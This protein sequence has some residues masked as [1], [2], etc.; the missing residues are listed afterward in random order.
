MLYGGLFH[1]FRGLI[2]TGWQRYDHFAVLCE[3]LPV[4]LPS[5]IVNLLV[6]KA[7]DKFSTESII[8]ATTTTLHCTSKISLQQIHSFDS[9]HFPGVQLFNAI[10]SLRDYVKVI[11]SE[12]FG[13][14][15]AKG[16]LNR[17]NVRHGYTQLWYLVQLK[18]VIEICKSEMLNM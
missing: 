9:C 4:G 7:G 18:N 8:N 15:Q 10:H 14:N 17:F 1:T 6:A 13:S 2:I 11:E 16:W 12:V 3:L 5:A